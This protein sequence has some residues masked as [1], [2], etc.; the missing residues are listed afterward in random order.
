ME[1]RIVLQ[2]KPDY[3]EVSILCQDCGETLLETKNRT[4]EATASGINE[5]VTAHKENCSFYNE[6]RN[7]LESSS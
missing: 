5:V 6:A 2:V 3:F 1:I 7:M 4:W